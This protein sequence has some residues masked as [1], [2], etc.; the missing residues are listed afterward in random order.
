MSSSGRVALSHVWAML[1]A[2]AA[3]HV[4]KASKHYWCI[5]Y[6]EKT[7]PAFPLGEH[8][9]RKDPEI[10]VGHIKR[11]ARYLGILDCAKKHIDLK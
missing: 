2:C 10:Q 4:K 3:G 1:D 11:M 5:M 9:A 7:Y 6:G 8:G